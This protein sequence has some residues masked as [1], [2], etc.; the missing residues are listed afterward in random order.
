M[1]TKFGRMLTSGR[2]F[3]MQTF[4]CL[5]LKLLKLGNTFRSKVVSMT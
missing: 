1:V 4:S 5:V 2:R 3:R